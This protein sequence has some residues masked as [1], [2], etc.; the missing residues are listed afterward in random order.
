[1]FQTALAE[2]VS[3]LPGSEWAMIV[4]LDGVVLEVSHNELRKEAEMLAAEYANLMRASCNTAGRT[5]IGKVDGLAL[6]TEKGKLMLQSLT[7]DYIL[8]LR[9]QPTVLVGKALFEI[10]RTREAIVGELTF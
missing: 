6:S 2:L 4:G 9:V 5:S 7:P 10:F 1:M 8:L 3:R